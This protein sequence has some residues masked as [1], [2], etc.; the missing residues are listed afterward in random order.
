MDGGRAKQE[1]LCAYSIANLLSLPY[2]IG[3]TMPYKSTA[4]T[5]SFGCVHLQNHCV[6]FCLLCLLQNSMQSLFV[7]LF[8]F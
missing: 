2:A 6:G 5:S 8:F 3:G 7:P 4:F 1:V